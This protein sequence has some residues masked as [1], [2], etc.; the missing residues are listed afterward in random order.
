MLTQVLMFFDFPDKE[1]VIIN[2]S[3]PIPLF[4][5]I[6]SSLREQIYRGDYSAREQLQSENELATRFGV[7]R[8]TI[9][10][11]LR[12]LEKNQYIY[13]E[14]GKGYFVAPLP[15][16]GF[17]GFGSFSYKCQLLGY[18]PSSKMIH[19]EEVPLVPTEFEEMSNFRKEM[20]DLSPFYY[21]ERIR[22]MDG[23]P[24]AFE[25]NYLPKRLYPGLEKFD[26]E[27]QSLYN[28]MKEQWGIVPAKADQFFTV[29]MA[30]QTMAKF[31]QLEPNQ[32]LLFL[33]SLVQSV[34][35]EILEFSIT[36]YC[37]RF[38]PYHVRQQ[39]YQL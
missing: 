6:A 14:K 28:I 19:F 17:L 5:Q 39:S 34:R 12:E 24:A 25:K 22:L 10:H 21:M 13:R 8:V 35:N 30:D 11:A 37:K 9:R 3:S 36:V 31:L 20:Q 16:K 4:Y 29:A 1:A 18:A 23:I 2:K 15:Y 33:T 32:P 26:L 7:S 38:L 27:T